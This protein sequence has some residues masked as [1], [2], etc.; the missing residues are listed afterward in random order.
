[1]ENYIELSFTTDD[2][3]WVGGMPRISCGMAVS[4]TGKP[5]FSVV[6]QCVERLQS[7]WQRFDE[8]DGPHWQ[9]WLAEQC[10]I[11]EPPLPFVEGLDVED[12]R[13]RVFM[14]SGT[15]GT[16]MV[17]MLVSML[18]EAGCTEVEALI[19]C[20][21]SELVRD[22]KGE[23]QPVGERYY[24]DAYGQLAVVNYPEIE[25]PDE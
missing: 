25:C 10:R 11:C 14:I 16:N 2:P 7:W 20:D 15:E 1:V 23:L 22:N 8:L 9:R 17:R 5:L 24:I 4:R 12:N 18:Y 6:D 3:F 13:V 21:E 19:T